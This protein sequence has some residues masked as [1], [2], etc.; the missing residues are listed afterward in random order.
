MS[1]EIRGQ[2]FQI[3]LFLYVCYKSYVN[4][5]TKMSHKMMFERFFKSRS[6]SKS[7]NEI[8]ML[9]TIN[10]YVLVLSYN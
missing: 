9:K 8:Q 2:Y 10:K 5:V 4:H 3:Y 1:T 7:W 6:Q